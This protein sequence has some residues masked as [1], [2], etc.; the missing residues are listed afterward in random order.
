VPIESKRM[1]PIALLR[2]DGDWYESTKICLDGL[3]NHV[4]PGGV[5]VIDDYGHWEGCRRAVDEFIAGSK[6]PIF[7]NHIDYTGRYWIKA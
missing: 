2:L 1:G 3:Y 7:L 5:V 6:H 4:V